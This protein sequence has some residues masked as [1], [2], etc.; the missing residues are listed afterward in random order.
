MNKTKCI[1]TVNEMGKQES[2][3]NSECDTHASCMEESIML[4][5]IISGGNMAIHAPATP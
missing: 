1:G 5:P 2:A 3:G 4:I